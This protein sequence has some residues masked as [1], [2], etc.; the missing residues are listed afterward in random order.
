MRAADR[1]TALAA[2]A[3]DDEV[4]AAI[5]AWRARHPVC[6]SCGPRPEADAVFCS[7]CGRYLPGTCARCGTR[8]DETGARFCRTCGHRLAA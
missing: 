3:P 8:I 5:L 1:E 7:T 6:A 4:E 2:N